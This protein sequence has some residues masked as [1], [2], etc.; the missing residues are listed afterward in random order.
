MLGLN[1]TEFT[2]GYSRVGAIQDNSK[3]VHRRATASLRLD[4]S[5]CS[6]LGR[7]HGGATFIALYAT[8][9]IPSL[10]DVSS[11]SNG[12]STL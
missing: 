3:L 10:T 1:R 5:K 9:C 11:G 4:T 7:D 8:F 12:V 6:A 2:S